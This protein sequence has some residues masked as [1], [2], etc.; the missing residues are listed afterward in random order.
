MLRR[1]FYSVPSR[2]ICHRPGVR[3]FDDRLEC[4]LGATPVATLSVRLENAR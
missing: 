4:F 1:V 2:R 3:I